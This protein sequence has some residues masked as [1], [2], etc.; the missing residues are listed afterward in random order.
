MF[1]AC[2]LLASMVACVFLMDE[3]GC[4]EFRSFYVDIDVMRVYVIGA[5]G[6]VSSCLGGL[7]FFGVLWWALWSSSYLLFF[8][9]KFLA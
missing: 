1:S 9:S 8:I 7:F 6:H 4:L 5:D 2:L 3:I